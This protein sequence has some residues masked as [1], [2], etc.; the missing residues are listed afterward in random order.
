MTWA[1]LSRATHSRDSATT[2]S[3]ESEPAFLHF[4]SDWIPV[5]NTHPTSRDATESTRH[6]IILNSRNTTRGQQRTQRTLSPGQRQ[7]P[8]STSRTIQRSTSHRQ[9]VSSVRLFPLQESRALAQNLSLDTRPR[10]LVGSGTV[11]PSTHPHFRIKDVFLLQCRH[12]QSSLCSRGM[13]AILLGDTKVEL[14]S[15]DVPPA[16]IQTVY[17]DYTTGNC[18]YVFLSQKLNFQVSHL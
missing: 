15:T 3:Q 18:L 1:T 11:D 17:Q 10:G 7:I 2:Q 4:L 13:K 12:C 14:Y 5:L 16:N 9:D 6:Y 8:R